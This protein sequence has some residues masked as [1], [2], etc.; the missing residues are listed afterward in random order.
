MPDRIFAHHRLLWLY[1]HRPS[2][3]GLRPRAVCAD[4]HAEI[5][6]W[7]WTECLCQLILAL[8][9]IDMNPEHFVASLDALDDFISNPTGVLMLKCVVLSSLNFVYM[10]VSCG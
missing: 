2:F 7:V 9:A 1:H 5:F 3:R 4:L 6:E 8:D 10:R